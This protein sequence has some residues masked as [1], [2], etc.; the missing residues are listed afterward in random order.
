MKSWWLFFLILW[1]CSADKPEKENQLPQD[2]STPKSQQQEE[3]TFPPEIPPVKTPTPEETNPKNPSS[4]PEKDAPKPPKTPPSSPPIKKDI[5]KINPL[6]PTDISL[7]MDPLSPQKSINLIP[8]KNPAD[9]L[10]EKFLNYKDLNKPTFNESCSQA[11]LKNSDPGKKIFFA[12]KTPFY[13]FEV[14]VDTWQEIKFSWKGDVFITL[15]QGDQEK[16]EIALSSLIEQEKLKNKT[17]LLTITKDNFSL[18]YSNKNDQKAPLHLAGKNLSFSHL[19]LGDFLS[20]KISSFLPQN[21]LRIITE[22]LDIEVIQKNPHLN[23]RSITEVTNSKGLEGTYPMIIG[24]PKTPTV[25]NNKF[26]QS[27]HIRQYNDI[28]PSSEYKETQAI[29]INDFYRLAFAKDD[30]PKK[31]LFHE[32]SLREISPAFFFF[33]CQSLNTGE[34][35]INFTLENE[36]ASY[37][38][39]TL[40]H[41]LNIYGQKINNVDLVHYLERHGSSEQTKEGFITYSYVRNRIELRQHTFFYEFI[42]EVMHAHTDFHPQQKNFL[43]EW[44]RA[45]QTTYG[46]YLKKGSNFFLWKDGTHDLKYGHTTP[47]GHLDEYEDSC[48]YVYFYYLFLEKSP[49]GQRQTIKKMLDDKDYSN[50]YRQKFELLVKYQF[51]PKDALKKLNFSPPPSS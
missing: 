44:K 29:Y 35:K 42:H 46:K 2:T 23:V 51:L 49:E 40:C 26:L 1:G 43:T 16:K 45:N 10:E 20:L 13:T 47:Y 7:L 41:Y 15:I 6:P 31:L 34:E 8:S 14:E 19:S 48:E 18:V 12:L 30:H 50:V 32:V 27:N 28:A 17:L 38:E 3:D 22:D 5:K 24:Y 25:Y 33:P 4:K 37:L 9:C 39:K 36:K 21:R 11:A